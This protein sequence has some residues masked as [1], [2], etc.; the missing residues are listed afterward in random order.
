MMRNFKKKVVEFLEQENFANHLKSIHEFPRQKTVNS[1]ISLLCSTDNSIK[2]NAI[3]A[4]GEI[5][6]NLAESDIDSARMIMRRLTWSLNEESGWIGWGSAQAMGEIM[7]RSSK[8]ADEFHKFLISYIS[9]GDNYLQ[10][11]E[12]R[13]EVF[14]GLKRL[15]QA[16]PDL[17]NEAVYLL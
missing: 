15:S 12:L 3:I 16:R 4:L 17:V 9:E 10:F 1:L 13:K 8:L 11:D 5:V 2:K 6:S 14:Q 7:A